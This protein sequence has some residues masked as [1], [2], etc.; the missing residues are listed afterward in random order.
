MNRDRL[1]TELQSLERKIRLLLSQ[2]QT[3]RKENDTLKL[4]NQELKSILN[5]KDHQ[6]NDFQNKIKISTIVDSINVGEH[7]A[8]EVKS[9][10]NEYIREIDKCIKQLTK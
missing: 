6:L 4:E 5:S 2:Y 7:E 3:V 9:K 10:I 1:N 8:K